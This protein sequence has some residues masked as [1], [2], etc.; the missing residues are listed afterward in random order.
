MMRNMEIM[1]KSDDDL[2][3]NHDDED[4]DSSNDDKVDDREV[5]DDGVHSIFPCHMVPLDVLFLRAEAEQVV[6]VLMSMHGVSV[7]IGMVLAAHLFVVLVNFSI[8]IFM[9]ACIVG[10]FVYDKA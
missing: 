7:I 5:V 9:F 10:F 6:L 8:I 2:Y 3:D 1:A 4:G